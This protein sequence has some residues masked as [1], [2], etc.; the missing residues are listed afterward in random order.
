MDQE[1]QARGEFRVNNR[2]GLHMRSAAI[3]VRTGQGFEASI[4]IS[5]G[6][7]CADAASVLDLLT[8]AAGQGTVLVIEAT[9]S[10]AEQ[11]VA[12]LGELVRRGFAE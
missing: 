4:T 12:T 1:K 2:L 3:V 8:L 10:D 7:S 5:N 6:Q 11:A 9:G